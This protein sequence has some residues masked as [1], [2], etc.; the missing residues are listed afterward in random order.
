MDLFLTTTFLDRFSR[1]FSSGS[2]AL[3]CQHGTRPPLCS[4]AL[5]RFAES[6]KEKKNG[7]FFTLFF[8][9]KEVD[10]QPRSHGGVVQSVSDDPALNVSFIKVWLFFVVCV[11]VLIFSNVFFSSGFSS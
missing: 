1:S 10:Q 4:S 8:V 2:H 3:V 5:V 6:E 7:I 11:F 9:L